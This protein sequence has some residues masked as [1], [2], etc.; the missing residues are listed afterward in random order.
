[1][2]SS[3]QLYIKKQIGKTTR[4]LPYQP[5]TTSEP[6]KMLT[7]TDAECLTAAGSLGVVLL[8]VFER[9]LPPMKNGS[10]TIIAR[11]IKAVESAILDLFKGT[12][13]EIDDDIAELMMVTWD[14]T[15]KAVSQGVSV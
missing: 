9:N 12:G 5:D 15:M 1:M 6:E 13:A 14:R 10:P 2:T 8:T 3:Q 11:K 7:F 4:Y